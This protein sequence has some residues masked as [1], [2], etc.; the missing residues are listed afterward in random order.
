MIAAVPFRDKHE[1]TV[2]LIKALLLEPTVDHVLG[3][4]NGSRIPLPVID[5]A[6]VTVLWLPSHGIYQMWDVALGYAAGDGTL[7]LCNNDIVLPFGAPG[8]MEGML[9]ADPGLWLVSPDPERRAGQG[10]VCPEAKP[11]TGSYRDQGILG[12]CMVMRTGPL[13]A[14]P[15]RFGS[16]YLKWWSGDDHLAA[17]IEECGGRMARALGVGCDHVSG[18]TARDHPWTEQAKGPD[19]VAFGERWPYR[20]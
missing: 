13:I 2:P 11:V 3:M 15:D 17:C 18:A 1:L 9:D 20:A 19:L 6:R 10:I 5:D 16:T 4:D 12:W 7:L 14:I 8:V